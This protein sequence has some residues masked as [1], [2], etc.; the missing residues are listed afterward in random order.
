MTV[1]STAA[2]QMQGGEKEKIAEE[3]AEGTKINWCD[4]SQ[5][6]Q[7]QNKNK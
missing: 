1:V 3:A 7:Q 4:A 2:T 6:Q 5:K